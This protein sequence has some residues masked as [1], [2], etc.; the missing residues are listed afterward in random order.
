MKLMNI[1]KPLG[2]LS[3]Y[4]CLKYLPETNNRYFKFV[5]KMRSFVGRFVF[6]YCGYN[7]NI[8]KGAN[9]GTGKGIKIGNNSGIGLNSYIRGPLEIGN[10]LMMGPDV[11]ILTV[12][13]L[14]NDRNIPM[15]KQ[16]SNVSPVKIQDDVWIGARVIILPGVTIGRGSVI[17][18]GS[19]VTKDIPEYCIVAGNPARV[20]K[21]RGIIT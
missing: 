5:R 9:F 7:V 2:L 11:L 15:R 20:I 18:A 19:V 6:D 16:G 21:E 13:H 12:N 3:Y 10:D 14:F 8:E 17:G 4:L 1:L